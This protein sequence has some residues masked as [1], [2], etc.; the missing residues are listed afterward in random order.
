VASFQEGSVV[1]ADDKGEI[2]LAWGPK[3]KAP[4]EPTGASAKAGTYRVRATRI[5]RENFLISCSGKPEPSLVVKDGAKLEVDETI[6][7]ECRAKRKGRRLDLGFVIKGADGRGL[8]VYKDGK[9]VPVTYKVLGKDGAVLA[10][11]TMNYG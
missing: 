4:G 6:R 2:T 10:E 11:G 5:V 9:R 8:S 3:E 7:F 1:L